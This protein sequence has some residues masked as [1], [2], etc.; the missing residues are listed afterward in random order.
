VRTFNNA[1]HGA[2]ADLRSRN[3]R[4]RSALEEGRPVSGG[5]AVF[6]THEIAEAT[7]MRQLVREGLSFDDAYK[8]AHPATIQKYGVSEFSVY[9][10]DVI[11]QFPGEFNSKF[12][13]FWGTK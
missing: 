4:V 11:Q 2:T 6:Y 1:L 12:R 5:D 8:I 10:P 9:H 13:G 3:I 7:K